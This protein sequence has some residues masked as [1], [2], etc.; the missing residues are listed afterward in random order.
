MTEQ[1]VIACVKNHLQGRFNKQKTLTKQ[2]KRDCI[3]MIKDFLPYM[4]KKQA[5]EFFDENIL[6]GIAFDSTDISGIKYVQ[7][8][9]GAWVYIAGL[10]IKLHIDADNLI[11]FGSELLKVGNAY[12]V[13]EVS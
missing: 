11:S 3:T 12:K 9:G 5:Q 8:D 4:S 7:G 6:K 13:L 10:N 1:E 2:D